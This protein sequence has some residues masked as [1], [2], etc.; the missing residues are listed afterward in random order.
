[1]HEEDVLSWLERIRKIDELI[2][3]K[4]A[5]REHAMA[6]ATKC[7]S[8]IDGMPRGGKRSDKVGDGAVKLAS[9]SEEKETLRRERDRIVK[10]L[11][12]LPTNEYGVL[13]REYA[14]NMTQ[15]EISCDMNYSTVQVWRIKKRALRLLGEILSNKKEG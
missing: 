3:A 5:E 8:S 9:L 11:E 14:R 2:Q 6:L 1:M 15:W 12:Q 13:H 4:D 10:T 7:T